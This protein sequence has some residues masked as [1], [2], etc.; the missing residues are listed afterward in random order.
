VSRISTP[1]L[2]HEKLQ[3]SPRPP[4]IL[5][6]VEDYYNEEDEFSLV[7]DNHPEDNIGKGLVFSDISEEDLNIIK[8][9]KYLQNICDYLKEH[10]YSDRVCREAMGVYNELPVYNIEF[11]SSTATDETLLHSPVTFTNHS[12]EYSEDDLDLSGEKAVDN[13]PESKQ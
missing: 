8:Q 10:G 9:M 2:V 11:D 12:L 7:N 1:E 3:G 6:L 5:S 4:Q 13:D